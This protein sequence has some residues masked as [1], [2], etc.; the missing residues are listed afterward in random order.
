MFGRR[1]RHINNGW[2]PSSS[3]SS[4][5]G[6]SRFV[7]QIDHLRNSRRSL[8][9]Y[10]R[11]S[12]RGRRPRR[13]DRPRLDLAVLFFVCF[14]GQVPDRRP[15]P[16]STH[17]PHARRH[18][19]DPSR[20]ACSRKDCRVGGCAWLR[21]S[22][23][24]EIPAYV[25]AA[26]VLQH[27]GQQS[28][29]PDVCRHHVHRASVP[30]RAC[31]AVA[32]VSVLH[33]HRCRSF[34]LAVT[35]ACHRRPLLPSPHIKQTNERT[36]VTR[37][38]SR[39]SQEDSSEDNAPSQRLQ[40]PRTAPC[41]TGTCSPASPSP[42]CTPSKTSATA[43]VRP[44]PNPKPNQIKQGQGQVSEPAN[45]SSSHSGQLTH[46]RLP[47]FSISEKQITHSS[48]SGLGSTASLF[49]AAS[50]APGKACSPGMDL[51]FAEAEVRALALLLRRR[52][53]R[54][55]SPRKASRKCRKNAKSD[56]FLDA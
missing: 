24:L 47:F 1:L 40:S 8:L 6:S 45:H 44:K 14:V 51:R 27:R 43:L 12:L 22:R 53:R 39:E 52:R 30:G 25:W 26:P 16:R 5:S 46:L 17:R 56:S 42:E 15:G 28:S 48:A 9:E 54:R 23:H 2:L 33:L 34:P 29:E 37:L 20:A 50:T 36:N 13:H 21:W 49:A 18:C 4:D 3:F 32:L 19:W 55:C 38:K 7:D 31:K 41:T 35:P 11:G 10:P